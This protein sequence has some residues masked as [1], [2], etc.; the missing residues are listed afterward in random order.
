MKIRDATLLT[1]V[2][3]FTIFFAFLYLANE[4]IVGNSF[5][6]LEKHEVE[7]NVERADA[8]LG[9]HTNNLA[10]YSKRLGKLG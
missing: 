10:I 4:Q 6:Q 2:V 5:G 1:I 7:K 9:T 3:V 8:A